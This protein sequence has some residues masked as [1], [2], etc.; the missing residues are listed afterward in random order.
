MLVQGYGMTK[1]PEIAHLPFPVPES[2]L[3]SLG[4]SIPASPQRLF[5]P[6]TSPPRTIL[7][8]TPVRVASGN[9]DPMW[10]VSGSVE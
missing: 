2:F 1:D 10:N 8:S 4:L 3:R 7:T 6:P 5:T 9:E